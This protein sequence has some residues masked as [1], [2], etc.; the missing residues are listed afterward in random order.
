MGGDKWDPVPLFHSSC[1][2]PSLQKVSSPSAGSVDL[3]SHN[4]VYILISPTPLPLTWNYRWLCSLTWRRAHW[5]H[6][7][8]R[9]VLMKLWKKWL[10]DGYSHPFCKL[11]KEMITAIWQG[12]YLLSLMTDDKPWV[13]LTGDQ[14]EACK[15]QG[16]RL[17]SWNCRSRI[18]SSPSLT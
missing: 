2:C 12:K 6:A 8:M 5:Q 14:L 11:G 15:F 16:I 3:S 1:R 17:L 10:W 18:V 4:L 13:T 7:L 9:T